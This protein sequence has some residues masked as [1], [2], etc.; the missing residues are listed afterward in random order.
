MSETGEDIKPDVAAEPTTE[1]LTRL[2]GQQ[3]ELAARRDEQILALRQHLGSRD[4]AGT[5]RTG[6]A[7]DGPTTAGTTPASAIAGDPTATETAQA[8]AT[9]PREAAPAASTPGVTAA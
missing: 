5:Q 9:A 8:P 3:L 6:G 1:M 4:A 7:G 2:L